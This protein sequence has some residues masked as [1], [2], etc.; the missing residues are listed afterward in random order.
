MP[1]MGKRLKSYPINPG[2]ML[3]LDNSDPASI[4]FATQTKR[5]K[6]GTREVRIGFERIADGRAVY[7]KFRDIQKAAS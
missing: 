2:T 7:A 5:T 1:L 4:Y 6:N 3:E